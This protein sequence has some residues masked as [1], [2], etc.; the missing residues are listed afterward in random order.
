MCEDVVV[1]K[2]LASKLFLC[3]AVILKTSD[4]VIKYLDEIIEKID[5]GESKNIKNIED[6]KCML[7]TWEN[8][9]NRY[10]FRENRINVGNAEPEQKHITD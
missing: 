7:L 6:T 9:W 4:F 1:Y 3:M 2:D 8:I 10:C 5:V